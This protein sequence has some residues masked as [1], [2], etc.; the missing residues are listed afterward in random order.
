MYVPVLRSTRLT[1]TPVPMRSIL[2]WSR[3]R[4]YK[5]ITSSEGQNCANNHVPWLNLM[6]WCMWHFQ[7][8][9]PIWNSLSDIHC[10][11]R[12]SPNPRRK[13]HSHDG[14]SIVVIKSHLL[15][16]GSSMK[17]LALLAQTNHLTDIYTPAKD[18]KELTRQICK[19]YVRR[20]RATNMDFAKIFGRL[21]VRGQ[22]CLGTLSAWFHDLWR[23]V[24]VF[25][26]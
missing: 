11:L 1:S 15:C 2:S 10:G 21:L 4:P 23:P 20:N 17:Q 25:F 8:L 19:I 7:D 18:C 3:K 16:S 24:R 5:G 22:F 26:V 9:P 13:C 6:F 12:S 14:R